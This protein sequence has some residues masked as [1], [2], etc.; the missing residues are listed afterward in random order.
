MSWVVRCFF[1]VSD[2]DNEELTVFFLSVLLVVVL[3]HLRV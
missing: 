3:R 1:F 2:S